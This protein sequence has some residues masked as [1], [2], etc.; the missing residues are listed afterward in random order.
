M[1]EEKINILVVD[2][3]E[4]TRTDIKRLLYFEEDMEIVGEA[5]DGKIAV[6]K[7]KETSPHI[8]LMDIN[9]PVMDGIASTEAI[10]MHYP[11]VSVIIISIQGEQEYL[12]KAM[13]A[14]AREY[15]VKPLSSEEMASTIR[16]VYQLNKRKGPVG[17]EQS[18]TFPKEK[19]APVNNY[20]VVSFFCG[21]GGTGKTTLASN[22]AVTLAKKKLKVALLDL[23]LQFGDVSV[24]F[25]LHDTRSISDLADEEEISSDVL[26]NY[27]IQHI[28]GVFIL[29]APLW[30]QDSEKVSPEHIQT[31][32][33]L[34]KESFDC[35]IVDTSAF[36]SDINL[37]AL[38]SSDL[39]L[40]PVRRDISTIK[41]V[42]AGLDILRSLDLE[43]NVKLLLNQSDLDLGVDTE[44][45]QKALECEIA[46][47]VTSD[48][49]LVLSS[50]NE[51]TPFAYKQGGTDIAGDI[52]KLGEKIINGFKAGSGSE[53]KTALFRLF[54]F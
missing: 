31:I 1:G 11:W 27:L 8:V 44:E 47:Q 3:I 45:L 19:L 9:M 46:H 50:I 43:E 39:I 30:P 5:S 10:T 18:A 33:D 48:D 6:E 20:K 53:R 7:V 21:K 28:S 24:M 36:F 29:G 22:L 15:L 34:L 54:S 42:K 40:L 14:G 13:A 26:D 32:L 37:L 16:H 23:D 25:N 35:V 38:E 51:G 2:D 41:N 12:K 52:D 4:Q 17:E 49:K